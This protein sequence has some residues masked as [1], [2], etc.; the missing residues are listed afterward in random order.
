MD[1]NPALG[2]YV[3]SIF[4]VDLSF[5]ADARYFVVCVVQKEVQ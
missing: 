4:V 2:F 3:L 1:C 5:G